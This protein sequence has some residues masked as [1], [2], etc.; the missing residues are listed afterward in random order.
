VSLSKSSNRRIE[1]DPSGSVA[2]SKLQRHWVEIFSDRIT[3]RLKEILQEDMDWMTSRPI[4]ERLNR[5][6]DIER[7][8]GTDA[9]NQDVMRRSV[10]RPKSGK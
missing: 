9:E 5:L 8:R 4:L 2:P 7:A 6:Y 10:Q 3:D 1:S